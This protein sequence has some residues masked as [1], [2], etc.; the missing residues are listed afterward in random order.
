MN[1]FVAWCIN[2]LCDP[3]VTFNWPSC[4]MSFVLDLLPYFEFFVIPKYHLH[5]L[6]WAKYKTEVDDFIVCITVRICVN[7]EFIDRILK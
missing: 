6:L 3:S 7:C 5:N 4:L 1:Y 2:A